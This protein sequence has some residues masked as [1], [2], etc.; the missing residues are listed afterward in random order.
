MLSTF[1][2]PINSDPNAY[3]V[4]STMLSAVEKFKIIHYHFLI[5]VRRNMNKK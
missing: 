3:Y 5:P 2:N 1:T 4:K